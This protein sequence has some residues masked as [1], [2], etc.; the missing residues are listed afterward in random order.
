M[1]GQL[2]YISA[3]CDHLLQKVCLH[4]NSPKAGMNFSIGVYVCVEGE[5]VIWVAFG[6]LF[7]FPCVDIT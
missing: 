7:C 2:E 5:S 3:H 1:R 4:G 6:V